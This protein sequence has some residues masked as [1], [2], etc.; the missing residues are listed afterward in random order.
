MGATRAMASRRTP[1]VTPT[2]TGGYGRCATHVAIA[3]YIYYQSRQ[4]EESSKQ[5]KGGNPM[6]LA[7]QTLQQP[8]RTNG[9]SVTTANA[10]MS[11]NRVTAQ[12]G[13][14]LPLTTPGT[15]PYYKSGYSAMTGTAPPRPLQQNQPPTQTS[16]QGAQG[17]VTPAVNGAYT[18]PAVQPPLTIPPGRGLATQPFPTP[19]VALPR[20]P[21]TT[22]NAMP[23][24]TFQ[25]MA[26]MQPPGRGSFPQG[27]PY[28]PYNQQFIPVRSN[29]ATTTAP[30][31]RRPQLPTNTTPQSQP[32]A[33]I[34]QQTQQ[35]TQPM[36]QQRPPAQPVTT[37]P[38][39][40]LGVAP[41]QLRQGANAAVKINAMPTSQPVVPQYKPTQQPNQTQNLTGET[42][43]KEK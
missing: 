25:G 38:L 19:T 36:Q 27:Y 17:K 10:I 12:Q 14:T 18:Y 41:P 24:S 4:K 35:Q 43:K 32:Q 29:I 11:A 21:G 39:S 1:A 37:N 3:Y 23:G 26:P 6:P 22:P 34:Q 7:S 15:S 40:S 2:N 28:V 16:P 20:G 13:V 33:Q 42:A 8:R 30:P 5:L 9:T 31:Q